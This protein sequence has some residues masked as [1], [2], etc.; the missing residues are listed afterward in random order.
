MKTPRIHDVSEPEFVSYDDEILYDAGHI[1]TEGK[2]QVDGEWVEGY[3][4]YDGFQ[5]FDE[6]ALKH[7]GGYLDAD[8][9]DRWIGPNLEPDFDPRDPWEEEET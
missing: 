9:S 6:D 5:E 2:R 8:Q 4:E 1:D 3:D 7:L